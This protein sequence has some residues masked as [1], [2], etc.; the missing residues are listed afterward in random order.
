MRLMTQNFVGSDE[1]VVPPRISLSRER[2]L[3]AVAHEPTRPTKSIARDLGV[4]KT[5]VLKARRE[6]TA[7][8]RCGE[9]SL[10]VYICEMRKKLAPYGIEIKTVWGH[11]Y[12]LSDES[13]RII[14]RRLAARDA[15]LIP[16]APAK[17]ADQQE[18]LSEN[19]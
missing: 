13:R 2:I 16:T 7:D 17:A 1:I 14:Y 19:S 3:D 18:S 5:T 6:G 12:G 8:K 11:G 9:G 4:S 10:S 15:G